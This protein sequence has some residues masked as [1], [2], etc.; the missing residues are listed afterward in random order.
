[1][2]AQSPPILNHSVMFPCAS[3]PHSSNNECPILLAGD[4]T[5]AVKKLHP[6][7]N[8]LAKPCVYH[9]VTKVIPV[10]HPPSAKY[11]HGNKSNPDHPMKTK[12]SRFNQ[13]SISPKS[14]ALLD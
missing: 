1:M 8:E 4:E 6:S 9:E 3:G 7:K 5:A 14:P 11:A 12:R 2:N 13:S 10:N